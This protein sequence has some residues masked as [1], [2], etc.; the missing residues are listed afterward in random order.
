MEKRTHIYPTLQPELDARAEGYTCIAGVD[1]AGRGPLAGPVVAG[2]VILPPGCSVPEGLDDSKKL[3]AGRRE[4]LLKELLVSEGVIHG[5]GIGSVQ[6]IE[7]LNILKATHLAMAR[8]VESLGVAVDFCLID[9]LP[10]PGFPYRQRAIVK[11]DSISLS[12]AAASIIAKVTRDHMMEE[13]DREFPL[14]GF[15]KHKGYGTKQHLE[16]LRK[17]GP[18]PLH[19]RTFGP[20]SQLELPFI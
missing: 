2:A 19:R 3:T 17:H 1:E 20:V 9:G 15:A 16:A 8:A 7:C 6:E 11:G 5:V 18:C 4:A 13:A 10:V 14:Y 12:I